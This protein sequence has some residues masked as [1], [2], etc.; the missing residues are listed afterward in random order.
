M[1]LT[2][3]LLSL[4]LVCLILGI[5]GCSEDDGNN[6]LPPEVSNQ[7]FTLARGSAEGSVVG[8][9]VA[10]DADQDRL[11]FSITNGNT[12]DEPELVVMDQTTD[13]I[14]AG[15]DSEATGQ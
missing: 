6:N 11:T 10:T 8:T 1:K 4:S 2:L 5:T 13:T 14:P 3:N 12:D 7:V 9:V 15:A